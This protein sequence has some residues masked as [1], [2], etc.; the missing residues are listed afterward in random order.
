VLA[1][2]AFAQAESAKAKPKAAG[3]TATAKQLHKLFDEEW[4]YSLRENPTFASALGDKRYNDRWEDA[5]LENVERQHQHTLEVQKK[6]AAIGRAKLS[7]ADQINYD[8]FKRSVEDA[9]GDYEFKTYLL[10]LNQRG[11]IQTLDTFTRNLTF[12]TT[13]DYAD[14][15]ARLNAF[16]TLMD[17]TIALMREGVKQKVLHPKVIMQRVPAQIDRQ[18]VDSPEKSGYY[19]PFREMASHVP[20]AEQERLRAAAREAISNK[21]FPAYKK[22]KDFFVSE[23]LP[24]SFNDVGVWRRP[25]GDKAYA[26]YTRQYTTTNLTPDQI[27]EIGLK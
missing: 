15:L 18:I 8:M 16:P 5:S 13:K 21:I 25:N 19:G 10:P 9:L 4:E 24:A 6:L 14:W 7:A 11:G 2:L 23:Y 20:T 26:F 27:H 1:G 3:K 17:Q 12:N 22:L